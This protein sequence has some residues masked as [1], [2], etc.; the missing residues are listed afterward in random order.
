MSVFFYVLSNL[1]FP[2]L[3]LILFPLMQLFSQIRVRT[4]PLGVDPTTR[5]LLMALGGAFA[6]DMVALLASGAE[7]TQPRLWILWGLLL[8]TIRH[9]WLLERESSSG[10]VSGPSLQDDVR[11]VLISTGL[12]RVL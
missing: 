5:R 9:D 10:A 4:S 1:G 8:A 12:A 6:A 7:I 3:L 11:R 2:G